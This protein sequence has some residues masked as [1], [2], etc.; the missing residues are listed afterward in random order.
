MTIIATLKPADNASAGN[1]CSIAS[2]PLSK[3]VPWDGNVRKTGASDGLE[4][5]TASIAA[6][7]GS[8]SW[9]PTG[10]YPAGSGLLILSYLSPDLW[11]THAPK[12][13]SGTLQTQPIRCRPQCP[14]PRTICSSA[15]SGCYSARAFPSRYGIAPDVCPQ[16]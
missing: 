2:I 3:L 4:E 7:A 14:C 1:A 16:V 8:F 10:S 9:S 11:H 12:P 15:R 13:S 6:C 5:L